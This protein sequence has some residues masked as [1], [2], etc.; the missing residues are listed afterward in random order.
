MRNPCHRG[1]LRAV[2]PM[3]AL[4]VCPAAAQEPAAP[5]QA[6]PERLVQQL[7]DD[8]QSAAARVQLVALGAGAVPALRARLTTA[9]APERA[10]VLEVLA[11]IG[12]AAGVAVPDVLQL[13]Q[14]ARGAERA[15]F[16]ALAELAPWRPADTVIDASAMQRIALASSRAAS[17]VLPADTA[18]C[19]RLSRR[20][21]FPRELDVA[22]LAEI[23]RGHDPLQ[24]E[25]AIEHLGQ[26]GRA[27]A[28]ALPALHAVLAAPEPRVLPGDER[29]PLHAKATAAL[30]AIAPP[31]GDANALAAARAPGPRDDAALPAR[32]RARVDELVAE[33]RDPA[34]RDA[35]IA[36]LVAFG[37]PSA[38]AVG[39]C[40]GAG[41]DE[42]V[43]TAA[44]RVVRELGPHAAAAVPELVTAMT[45]LGAGH[46]PD[47]LEAL[48]V[49][50]PWARD[51]VPPA[52]W[53]AGGLT[54][55]FFDRPLTEGVDGA[56]LTRLSAA[57]RTLDAALAVSVCGS[58]AEL[59]ALLHSPDVTVRE[60]ALVV[61]AQRGRD[62]E[63]LAP[64]VAAAM[65]ASHPVSFRATWTGP[66][67]AIREQ[68]DRSAHVQRLAAT[69]LLA[70]SRDEKL[71]GDARR[72]LAEPA[73]K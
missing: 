16:V 17:R 25:L 60:R 47:V 15:A 5:A 52:T 31:G 7:D 51:V 40:L 55:H 49:A 12:P 44:L 45:T 64:G 61:I 19:L 63:A 42:A 34:R 68:I 13:L 18:L 58:A 38:A 54:L 6:D 9:G 67:K 27:A 8:A 32:A 11:A 48:V 73:P 50:A 2:P 35:A 36:N 22:T 65:A 43:V 70:I 30:R 28:A 46:L 57:T 41:H 23:V 4:A 20:N 1:R 59:G 62:L 69:A 53:F 39:R 21:A 14:R 26:R 66:D 3:L 29:L 24:R 10:T 33:L 72:V 56:L 37:E 71:R